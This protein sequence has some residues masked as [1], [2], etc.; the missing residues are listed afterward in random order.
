MCRL[1]GFCATEP[2][3]VECTLVHAQNALM[4][5]SRSDLTGKSHS[6][7]WG[8]V[9]YENETP[10]LERQVWAAYHGEH[11]RRSATNIYTDVVVAHVRRAT[12]G[13]PHINN[14][15]PFA[16]GRW[17]FA[18]NGTVPRFAEVG[19]NLLAAMPPSFRKKIKGHTDSEHLFYYMMSLIEQ[20]GRKN[21]TSVIAK[22][23]TDVLKWVDQ[24][25][26]GSTPGLNIMLTDG[27]HIIGTR[28][29]RTLYHVERDGIYDCEICGFPHIHHEPNRDYRAVVVASEPITHETWE[30]IPEHSLWHASAETG[31][32]R[33]TSL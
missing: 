15:H 21:V 12:V 14:T 23:I 30:E 2:T 4:A 10:H 24:P 13:E 29:G 3:K 5:Q 22:A 8:V 1:Y 27:E 33:I 11:F 20:H 31:Q 28:L 19:P 26:A 6:H 32:I 25:G 18:H 16:S 17:A 9:T 7:G